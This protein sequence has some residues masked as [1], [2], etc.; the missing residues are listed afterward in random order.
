[1]QHSQSRPPPADTS[2]TRPP[3]THTD[4]GTTPR[5]QRPRGFLRG[6]WF[7]FRMALS[8]A[9]H[10]L[11]H[12]P[13]AWIELTAIVA[14][15]LAAWWFRL[16]AVEWALLGA[17]MFFILALEAVNTALEA[18]V[19]RISP[20]FHPLAKRAKDTAAGAMVFAVLGS[21]WVAVAIF[22][23]RLWALWLG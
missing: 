12:E 23:P 16:R 15:S 5:V 11:R 9:L 21:L 14:V 18:V 19:D 7:S 13:N 22:G 10:V 6:R 20:E 3:A 8:G 1:M 4:T 2:A 17:V